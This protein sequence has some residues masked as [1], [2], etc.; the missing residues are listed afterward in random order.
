MTD[1]TEPRPS[2]PAA[3]TA[4]TAPAASV[5]DA[6]PP[7]RPWYRHVWVPVAGA[8]VLVLLAFGSGVVAGQAMTWFGVATAASDDD[9]MPGWRDGGP[10]HDDRGPGLPGPRHDGDGPRGDG[11]G[12]D[13]D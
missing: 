12:I 3:S 9:G 11:R 5:T 13:A 7:R 4:A 1:G 6:A 2:T 10:G 8:L